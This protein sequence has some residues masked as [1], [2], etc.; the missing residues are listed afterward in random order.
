[1]PYGVMAH[2]VEVS[3]F[4]ELID[5]T[6]SNTDTQSWQSGPSVAFRGVS[7]KSYELSSKLSRELD[8]RPDT[9]SK[10]EPRRYENSLLSNFAKY[11]Y[12]ELPSDSLWKTMAI[13]QHYRLPT[14][15][16]DWTRSP[17]VALHF[18]VE[19]QRHYCHD[20]KIWMV[21]FD[22]VHEDLPNRFDF[23]RW[24]GELFTAELLEVLFEIR[25]ERISQKDEHIEEQ[26]QVQNEAMREITDIL[27]HEE[28]SSDEKIESVREAYRMFDVAKES[29]AV[30]ET[31]KIQIK[32]KSEQGQITDIDS[33]LAKFDRGHNM[34]LFFEPPS[35]DQRIVNQSALFSVSNSLN[36]THQHAIENMSDRPDEL[37]KE[38]I[39]PHNKKQHFR[40][41]LDR[42]NI[43][44]R[45]LFPDKEGLAHW[46]KRTCLP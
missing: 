4:N 16:I 5:E 2:S 23:E 12:G 3:T 13:A 9:A 31:D 42:M 22:K 29:I 8:R 35:I 10:G 43:T 37:L 25:M 21:D 46:L 44:E 15:L 7:K 40:D 6:I 36:D 39:I 24:G 30:I 33:A 45:A 26:R 19:D 34:V 14:R 20:G 18:A 11:G 38:I 41:C 27:D 1:M 17:L 28:M 32:E